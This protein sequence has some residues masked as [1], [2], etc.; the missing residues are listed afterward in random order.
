MASVMFKTLCCLVTASNYVY[1]RKGIRECIFV[2]L[3]GV[4]YNLHVLTYY[5]NTTILKT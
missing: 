3:R 1:N 4:K 5:S 2:I